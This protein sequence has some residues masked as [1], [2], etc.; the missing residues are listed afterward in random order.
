V[1]TIFGATI[2]QRVFLADKYICLYFDAHKKRKEQQKE[3]EEK[4]QRNEENSMPIPLD[5]DNS[6]KNNKQQQYYDQYPR[7][8]GWHSL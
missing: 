7:P 2:Q 3:L 1:T 4:R 8:P 6:N 5:S